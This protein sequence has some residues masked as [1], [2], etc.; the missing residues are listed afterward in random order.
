MSSVLRLV[1]S[2]L[3]WSW[4]WSW[5]RLVSSRL[6]QKYSSGGPEMYPKTVLE[7]LW[8]AFGAHWEVSGG[9][10]GVLGAL[11]AILEALI[12]FGPRLLGGS[13]GALGA[14]GG[15]CRRL[16]DAQDRPRGLQ[17]RLGN[18]QNRVCLETSFR[19][20]LSTTFWTTLL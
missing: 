13:W 15:P 19:C 3:S 8:Q 16:L 17:N 14:H 1:L 20:E 12:A 9:L 11:E 5:S 7:S 6:A 2:V 18:L 4:C 10:W